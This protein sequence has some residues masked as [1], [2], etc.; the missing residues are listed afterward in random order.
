MEL[1]LNR[2]N[3]KVNVVIGNLNGAVQTIGNCGKRSRDLSIWIH[4]YTFPAEFLQRSAAMHL[5]CMYI[6]RVRT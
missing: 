2:I 4:D 6:P 1:E 3:E 5:P